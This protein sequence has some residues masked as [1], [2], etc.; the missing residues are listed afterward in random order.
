M[1]LEPNEGIAK[2]SASSAAGSS[3]WTR[4]GAD[5]PD[6]RDRPSP[7]GLQQ[8]RRAIA[9]L[10]RSAE[11]ERN[12]IRLGSARARPSRPASSASTPPTTANE[13][14]RQG[15]ESLRRRP[16]RP[17]SATSRARTP[18]SRPR[19]RYRSPRSTTT[20]SRL[21]RPGHCRRSASLA[22]LIPPARGRLGSLAGRRA[23]HSG[24]SRSGKPGASPRAMTT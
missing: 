5:D 23:V 18:R 17:R 16:G 11:G 15:R 6:E 22:G 9:V 19:R 13:H 2:R 20:S 10:V 24:P 7:R 1:P 4:N 3:R 14:P 8:A 12:T 21:A